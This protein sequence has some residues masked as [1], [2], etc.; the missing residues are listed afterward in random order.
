ML[1]AVTDEL[2]PRRPYDERAFLG[3]VYLSEG[4]YDRLRALLL[5]KKNVILAGPPGVGKTYAAQRLAYSIMGTKDPHPS[6]D[7]PV[8]SELLVRGLHDGVPADRIRR[9]HAHRGPVLPVLRGGPK[10]RRRPAVLLHRRR[11]QPRQ[12]L[13]DLRRTAR[14]SSRPTSAARSCDSSTRTRRSPSRA[15][16]HII[17]MMNTADRSLAVLDYALRRR[18]GFFEMTPGFDSTGFTRVAA[19]VDSPALDALSMSSSTSI[20]RSRTTPRSA[21]DSPI[22]HSFLSP[23]RTSSADD[24]WLYSVVEDELVPLLDEYWFDE[25][26]T[27]EQW[28]G[29][30]RD[31]VSVIDRTIVIRNV[32]VMLAYAFRAMHSTAPN[33]SPPNEFDH[34]HDLLAE[35]LV[36]GV[37]TQIKRGLHRDYLQRERGTRHGARAAST[38][39]R[40]VAARTMTARTARVRVRRVRDRHPSQPGA[41]VRHRAS[42]PPRRGGQRHGRTRCVESCPI[43]TPSR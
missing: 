26:E 4:D 8:P 35:I 1:P 34:L 6:P 18:F 24:A 12:H 2:V 19:A 43:S 15:N 28:A 41:E 5:R 14:C 16:V 7:G 9:L 31:A 42:H 25:P 40:T 30:L 13:E 22:G 23:A 39:R 33:A 27:A 32:Y 11:D 37:G 10:G 3:E 21:R 17:G 20:R 38:S 36:R 29:K